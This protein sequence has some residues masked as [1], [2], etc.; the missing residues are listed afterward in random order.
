MTF[1]G[2]PPQLLDPELYPRYSNGLV[3]LVEDAGL[4]LVQGRSTVRAWFYGRSQDDIKSA[5][6]AIV[7]AVESRCITRPTHIDPESLLEWVVKRADIMDGLRTTDGFHAVWGS[8][9]AQ[10]SDRWQFMLPV[11]TARIPMTRDEYVE[12]TR[13]C[14]LIESHRS[15]K[16]TLV[17]DGYRRPVYA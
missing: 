3:R 9:F 10:L 2:I 6:N 16:R 5:I 13:M 1:S 7:S 4:Q 8:N 15:D 14:E 17:T 11:R 12:F